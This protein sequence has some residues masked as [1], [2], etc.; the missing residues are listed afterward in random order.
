M[1]SVCCVCDVCV[2]SCVVCVCVMLLRSAG[3]LGSGIGLGVFKGDSCCGSLS[4]Y[5]LL[6]FR[7]L[8][9][10][11]VGVENRLEGAGW[12]VVGLACGYVYLFVFRKDDM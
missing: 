2:C 9:V 10:L 11:C 4:R 1:C 5:E 3:G 7:F 8:C 6:L 12:C